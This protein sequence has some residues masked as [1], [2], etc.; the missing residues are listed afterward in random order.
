M[1]KYSYLLLIVTMLGLNP[2]TGR[3]EENVNTGVSEIIE[4]E[5]IPDFNVLESNGQ[6]DE[7]SL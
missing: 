4:Q 2:I 1:K 5:I 7:S 3:A 6:V